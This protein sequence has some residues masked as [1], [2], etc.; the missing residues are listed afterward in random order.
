MHKAKYL[1][2]IYGFLGAG[3]L[4]AMISLADPDLAPLAFLALLFYVPGIIVLCFFIYRMWAA[5][6]DGET[7][8]TPGLAVGLI[9]VPLFNFYWVFRVYPGF[10]AEYNAYAARNG[11]SVPALPRAPY[12]VL[13]VCSVLGIIPYLGILSGLVGLILLGVVIS[14]TC[15][16]VNRLAT[17]PRGEPKD[18]PVPAR[19]GDD[20]ALGVVALFLLLWRLPLSLVMWS[21][22][23]LGG[24]IGS[25]VPFQILHV[26]YAAV[27]LLLGF[28][29]RHPLL[30]WVVIGVGAIHLVWH[31]EYAF[32]FL[33]LDFVGGRGYFE[34]Y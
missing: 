21:Y 3:F 1:W 31:A 24:D 6:Q 34:Y 33:G 16:A 27:P 23:E 8:T 15:D 13:A 29:T 14:V 26:L 2:G 4:L 30:R 9:F 19:S 28:F 11:L 18:V 10:A 22:H 7:R 5:I 17:A 20:G 32:R 12:A 25:A